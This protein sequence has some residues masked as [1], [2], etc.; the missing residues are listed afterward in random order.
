MK[1]RFKRPLDKETRDTIIGGIIL[2]AELVI[3]TIIVHGL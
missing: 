3:F 2:F 1:I